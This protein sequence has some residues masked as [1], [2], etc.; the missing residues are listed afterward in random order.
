MPPPAAHHRLG[1]ARA[2]DA[3]SVRSASCPESLRSLGIGGID[4]EGNDEGRAFPQAECRRCFPFEVEGHG[5]FEVGHRLIDGLALRDHSNFDAFGDIARFVTMADH[6]LNRL[7]QVCHGE[8]QSL[9][10]PASQGLC[11]WPRIRPLAERRNPILIEQWRSGSAAASTPYA[12]ALGI[13][14]DQRV[15]SL[16]DGR[17]FAFTKQPDGRF[18]NLTDAAMQ[19]A[20]ITESGGIP[21]LRWKDGAVWTFSTPLFPFVTSPLAGMQDRNGNTITLT[22]SGNQVTAIAGPDGRQLTLDYDGGGRITKVTDPIGRIVQ[23][24][25]DGS[26]NLATVTDPEG[27]TTRRGTGTEANGWAKHPSP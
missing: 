17:R 6:G 23:Y 7:L 11:L 18:I 13:Q 4:F 14:G 12:I 25:Y 1:L 9:G 20:V 2:C 26:G 5:F 21:S 24:A 16:A 27:G 10:N 19:G 15:L 22:R 8:P 3:P